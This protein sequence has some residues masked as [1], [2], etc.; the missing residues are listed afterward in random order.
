MG[1]HQKRKREKES[2]GQKSYNYLP[3]NYHTLLT[4]KPTTTRS[5]TKTLL[6]FYLFLILTRRIDGRFVTFLRE[7][8]LFS[9]FYAVWASVF[10]LVNSLFFRFP[11][12]IYTAPFCTLLL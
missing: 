6:T 2:E 9:F 5:R 1:R 12:A 7:Y 11:R 3:S 10:L 8:L 4:F